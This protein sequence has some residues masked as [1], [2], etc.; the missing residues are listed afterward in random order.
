M[1]EKTIYTMYRYGKVTV[2]LKNCENTLIQR[3][4]KTILKASFVWEKTPTPCFNTPKTIDKVKK[5]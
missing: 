1:R 5:A 4:T 3:M 2:H